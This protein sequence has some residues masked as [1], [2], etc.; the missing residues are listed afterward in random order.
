MAISQN[1]VPIRWLSGPLDIAR[2]EKQGDLTPDARKTLERWHLPETLEFLKNS[3]VDCLVVTWAAGMPEDSAQQ[4]SLAPLLDAARKNNFA[5]VGW[6][7]GTVSPDAAL[8]AA[9]SAGLSAVALHNYRGKSEIPVIPWGDRS[10]VPYDS[11]APVIAVSENVW[12]GVVLSTG[13]AEA[14]AGPTGLP[15]VDSNG[16]FLRMV[17]AR[18]QTPVWLLFDPPGKGTIQT[19]SAYG[20]AICDGEAAGGRWVVSFDD[21]LRAGLAESNP[22]ALQS[23]REISAVAAFFEKHREWRSYIPLG[24]VGV[25]S[26][27]GENNLDLNGELLNLMARRDLLYQVIW[28]SSA[29]KQPF[30]GLKGLVSVDQDPPAPELRRK[31]LSFVESG[32]LLVTNKQWGAEGQPSATDHR[33]FEIRVRGKG[34]IAVAKE[35]LGDPYELAGD[36]QILFSHA[37]DLV[38]FFNSTSSGGTQ[39]TASPDGKKSLVQA[40]TYSGGG[41]SGRGRGRGTGTVAVAGGS[42]GRGG[43]GGGVS[44]K[45]L[46]LKRQYRAARL[47]QLDA[48]DAVPIAAV[49]AEDYDG[50]EIHLPETSQGYLAIE[51]ED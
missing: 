16:W 44:L 1:T 41:R 20:M 7:E 34:R 28:K 17:R 4:K 12:P 22:A 5:T 18:V 39:Y 47:W 19:A 48:P 14:D 36:I 31:I 8:N 37:N 3:P 51:L 33:R 32:G 45:T 35:D 24:L 11:T 30:T 49:K 6:V 38:K 43:T 23:W 10:A 21:N 25:I 40:L 15:W 2:R 9:G 27:F 42:A 46:W 13:A 26:D 50:M 29:M